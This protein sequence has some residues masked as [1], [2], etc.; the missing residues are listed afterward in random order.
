MAETSTCDVTARAEILDIKQRLTEA[1][2]AIVGKAEVTHAHSATDYIGATEEQLA[3]IDALA[4]ALEENGDVMAAYA[5]ADHTH[6]EYATED[7]VDTAIAE[8]DVDLTGYATE[9]YVQEQ[10]EAIPEVDLSGYALKNHEHSQ[11]LTEHQSLEGYATETYVN[12]KVAAIDVPEVDLSGYAT[13]DYVD[14]AVA[15]VEVDLTD[16]ATKDYVTQEINEAALSGDGTAVDL[17]IYALKSE[18]PE[19][20][21]L[22][23]YATEEY[24]DDKVA[25]IEVPEV[26]LTNYALKSEIPTVPTNVSAFTNDANYVVNGNA[27]SFT[28]L[29]AASDNGMQM[30]IIE[31]ARILVEDMYQGNS[32]QLN[33]T[34]GYMSIN[35]NNLATEAYVTEQITAALDSIGIAED[36]EY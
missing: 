10:I 11:Y 7:Y 14:T 28:M 36:G 30:A 29:D 6:D 22:D 13:T 20:P 27:A 21:S 25:N 34:D 8:F 32:L 17:S 33:A 26:D 16:Y 35:G 18:I 9:T 23:G 31:P 4:A 24:V 12:D 19:V 3:A 15:N 5:L 1:E 2:E